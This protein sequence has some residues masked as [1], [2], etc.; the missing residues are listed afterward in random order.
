VTTVPFLM[1]VSKAMEFSVPL[2]KDK[3]GI[4]C[5]T[6]APHVGGM[7]RAPRCAAS[8]IFILIETRNLVLACA[9]EKQVP[10]LHF[11]H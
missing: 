8:G 2:L 3:K 11:A 1:M 5:Y 9:G 6:A 4:V 10:R 7:R